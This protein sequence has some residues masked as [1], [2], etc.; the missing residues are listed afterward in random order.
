MACVLHW[1]AQYLWHPGVWIVSSLH[2]VLVPGTP[3]VVL[4]KIEKAG[5]MTVEHYFFKREQSRREVDMEHGAWS[6]TGEDQ[7]TWKCSRSFIKFERFEIDT[8]MKTDVDHW[9][10]HQ[11][12]WLIPYCKHVFK[13]GLELAST[14]AY[15]CR[16]TR[17]SY[18]RVFLIE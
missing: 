16:N 10:D 8:S 15:V 13:S 6:I 1:S 3:L 14:H 2:A 7:S 18:K 4:V 17:V 11:L 12:V 9:T 5:P